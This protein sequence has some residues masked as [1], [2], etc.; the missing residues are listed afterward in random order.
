ME[1]FP[2][3]IAIGNAFCNRVKERNLLKQYIQHG[4]H[5]VLIAPRRYGKSSL[6][7]Q[8]LSELKLPFCLVELTMAASAENIEQILLKEINQL[9]YSILPKTTKAKQKILTLFKWLNPQLV[10]TAGGQKLI[11][12]PEYSKS[13][14]IENISEVL[15]KLDKAAA[16][17]KKRVVVVMDEFQQLS[18]IKNHTAEASVRH[19]MQYSR[20]V[21][22][23]FSGS[24]RR[25][26]INMFT[27][28]NRPFYNSC[29]IMK[30]DRI[31]MEDYDSFIQLAA[32]GKWKKK[33]PREVLA[34]IYKI[35]EFHPAYINRICGYFWLIGEFPTVSDIQQRWFSFIESKRAEFTE[36]LLRLSN[37]QKK[38][39]VYLAKNPTKHPSSQEV[40]TAIKLP[41]ASIRQAV[42]K[43]L[44]QDYVYKNSDGFFQILDPAM[45][46]FIN[47][48]IA[49]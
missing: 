11:F 36:D 13:K 27:N 20:Y 2:A 33:L 15:I 25:M 39:L 41:E 48:L 31:S 16:I 19:A 18:E 24:N 5:T 40:S 45:R 35:T 14:P 6:I 28:K 42:K 10:L 1:L 30:I 29:E 23:V 22:Y 8:V 47:K 9:L 34:A 21:S 49:A 12:H 4:R 3:T 7:N 38:L 26:L 37:N 32:Y 17:L 44:L 43:L 46:D